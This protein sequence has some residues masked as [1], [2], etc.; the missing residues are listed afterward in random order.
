MT[1]HTLNE[2]PRVGICGD[3]APTLINGTPGGPVCELPHGHAGWHEATNPSYGMAPTK[4]H[5]SGANTYSPATYFDGEWWQHRCGD[6]DVSSAPDSPPG[7]CGPCE[8]TTPADQWRRLY[9][10]DEAGS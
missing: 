5:W 1:A 4:T 6:V 3:R 8:M 10:R 9:V 7:E 2:D